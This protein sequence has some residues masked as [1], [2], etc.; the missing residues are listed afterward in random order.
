MRI[1]YNKYLNIVRR[2]QEKGTTRSF[3]FIFYVTW[4]DSK[5]YDA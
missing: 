3:L 2:T 1:R 4:K 5:V